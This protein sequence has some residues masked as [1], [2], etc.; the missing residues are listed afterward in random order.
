MD[1]TL[2]LLALSLIENFFI[3]FKQIVSFVSSFYSNI[4]IINS[5]ALRAGVSDHLA[6]Q[7]GRETGTALAPKEAETSSQ[8][9][10]D[11]AGGGHRHGP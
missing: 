3:S 1:K 7:P 5:N 10:R 4:R 6:V 8:E 11:P 2:V 9:D